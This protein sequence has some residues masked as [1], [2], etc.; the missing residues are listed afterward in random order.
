M[1]LLS[2]CPLLFEILFLCTTGWDLQPSGQLP[3]QENEC[4]CS[5]C[6]VCVWGVCVCRQTPLDA[7]IRLL[8]FPFVQ[9][10]LFA[11]FLFFATGTGM[12]SSHF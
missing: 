6:G 10:P 8:L 1:I 12:A 2:G 9:F 3:G 5:V 11:C 7:E 4:V